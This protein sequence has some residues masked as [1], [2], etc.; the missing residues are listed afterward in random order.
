V[1][2]L[3]LFVGTA[4]PVALS[5]ALVSVDIAAIAAL[6]LLRHIPLATR[7]LVFAAGIIFVSVIA[8]VASQIFAATPSIVDAQGKPVPGS[9]ATLEK[10]NLNGSEQ[11]ITIRGRDINNPVLLYLGAGGPG[12]GGFATRPMFEPLEGYFTI[13]AWDE[14][15]TGKSYG[16]VPM[17]ALTKRRFVDDAYALTQLLRE[18]FRQDKIYVYGVS[19]T[20]IL[21]IWL[22]QEYPDLYH[23]YIG[24]GQ[25]VNTT[26]NDV[27]GY[28]LALRYAS[29]R[30]DTAT[31]E[32]LTRN[33]PPPYEGD[34]MAFRY[35]AFLDVLNDY[36]GA[37]R[38][39]LVVPLMP[40]FAPEYGHVDKVNHLRGLIESFTVVYPQLRD[41]DFRTQAARLDVPVYLFAGRN[42]VNAMSSLAEEY[43]NVLRATRKEIIWFEAGH[44]LSDENLDQFVDSMINKVLAD[45]LPAH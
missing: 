6:I 35:V 44:G 16:A 26:E 12:A 29:E 5:L 45:T 11:W 22:V 9:I 43:F 27:M 39:T 41:L 8:I 15:G 33:G 34:G 7:G 40:L 20:S 23:A 18:R 24:N 36:M 17:N 14:P 10:V 38:Y 13:V 32:T 25:M 4:V 30:G 1:P 31:V 28:E 2:V 42:D 19:W 21:G 37:P 3:L